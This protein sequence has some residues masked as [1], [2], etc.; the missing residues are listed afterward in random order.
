MYTTYQS[1]FE[2]KWNKSISSGE[3]EFIVKKK[4]QPEKLPH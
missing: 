3:I 2:K 1:S 4:K